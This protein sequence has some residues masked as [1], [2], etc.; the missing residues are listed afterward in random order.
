MKVGVIVATYNG[1]KFIKEQLDSILNQTYKVDEIVISDDGSSDGT[2]EYLSE[3]AKEHND[4]NISIVKNCGEHGPSKNFENAYRNSTADVLFFADQDDTWMQ[5]KVEVFM[6]A[7]EKHPECGCFFSDAEV[8]DGALN[9]TGKTN[10]DYFFPDV[11]ELINN[12][13][14]YTIINREY[15]VKRVR[16]GNVVPGMCMAVKREVL[17]KTVPFDSIIIHDDIII[18]YSALNSQ[19]CCINKIEAYYR[20]HENNSIGVIGGNKDARRNSLAG[21]IKNSEVNLKSVLHSYKRIKYFKSIDK[22]SEFPFLNEIFETEEKRYLA[23]KS[24]CVFG[25][26]RLLKNLITKGRVQIHPIKTFLLDVSMIVF[27][28]KKKR[29]EYFKKY[30]L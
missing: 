21:L 9:P 12:D 5:D 25:F 20:Q 11:R 7:F 18:M 15:F 14:I 27:V 28:K 3:Y 19:I 13:D 29:I 26:F 22:K 1:I 16:Y 10:F 30:N 23:A 24:N 4:Y 17:D 6:K 2:F 8:T